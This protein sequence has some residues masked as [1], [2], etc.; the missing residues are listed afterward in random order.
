[1]ILVSFFSE[2]I[3][4]SDKIIIWY[5]FEYQSNENRAFCFFGTP[6]IWITTHHTA[7]HVTQFLFPAPLGNVNIRIIRFKNYVKYKGH[8]KQY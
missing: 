5:S 4:L 8:I 3:A 2:D 1:M 6:G 7:D